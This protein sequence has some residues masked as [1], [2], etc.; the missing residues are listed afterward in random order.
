MIES[1]D[2]HSAFFAF[3]LPW[4]V[5]AA[6]GARP[7]L[8]TMLAVFWGAQVF[9]DEYPHAAEC[10]YLLQRQ[11]DHLGSALPLCIHQLEVPAEA[12]TAQPVPWA[13]KGGGRAITNPF[14]GR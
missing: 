10:N 8:D 13:V 7:Y 14:W 2:F 5:A 6:D 11:H 3:Y 1:L 9:V 4:S 12:F